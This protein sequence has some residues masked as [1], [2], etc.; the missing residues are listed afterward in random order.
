MV[1]LN[2]EEVDLTLNF[3]ALYKLKAK[4]P[5]V[6]YKYQETQKKKKEKLEDLDTCYILYVAYCCT[7]LEQ[8]VMS[9]EKFLEVIPY[10]RPTIAE[11]ISTLLFPSKK[12]KVLP[13]AFENQPAN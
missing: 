3:A 6:Y 1:L 2:G 5:K 7:H 11:I 13:S 10:D 9:F 4:M 12:K 8:A